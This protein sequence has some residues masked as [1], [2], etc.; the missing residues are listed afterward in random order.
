MRLIVTNDLAEKIAEAYN[1]FIGSK[2]VLKNHIIQEV[3]IINNCKEPNNK[4]LSKFI[5]SVYNISNEF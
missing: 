2:I 1:D 3:N 4:T 5:I